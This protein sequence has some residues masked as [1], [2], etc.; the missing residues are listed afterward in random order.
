[1][2]SGLSG[3][4]GFSTVV[5]TEGINHAGTGRS[6]LAWQ[7]HPTVVPTPLW[8]LRAHTFRF[9]KFSNEANDRK[10]GSQ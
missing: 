9:L 8:V 2:H 1:M 4:C 5:G 3:G 7:L 10:E 6:C